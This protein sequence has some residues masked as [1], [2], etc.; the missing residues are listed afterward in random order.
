M[1]IS[2]SV[3]GKTLVYSLCPVVLV[4]FVLFSKLPCQVINV[5][6]SVGGKTLVY[7]LCPVVLVTFVLF[8]KLPCQVINDL[9]LF[10]LFT[11][12]K[13]T[14]RQNETNNSKISYFLYIFYDKK[15]PRSQ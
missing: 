4:T 12:C 15:N 14:N 6:S 8:S 3:G 11:I 13:F 9:D 5:S 2:S 1:L 10:N 7:S